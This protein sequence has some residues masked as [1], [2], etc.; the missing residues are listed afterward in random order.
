MR[1]FRV[2]SAFHQASRLHRLMEPSVLAE[3]VNRSS[4]G[5]SEL[6]SELERL[7]DQL[8]CLG[9]WRPLAA[10]P[11]VVDLVSLE[12]RFPNFSEVIRYVKGQLALAASTAAQIARISPILLLGPPGVGKS[13]FARAVAKEMAV[14]FFEIPV[15]TTTA[16]FALTGGDSSWSG[17][18]PGRIFE[19]LAFESVSNPLI[20]LD[21]VDKQGSDL[22]YDPLA[23]LLSV[24]EQG[25]AKAFRDEYAAIPVDASL[26]MWMATAN[27]TETMPEPLLS[28]FR[29]FDIPPPDRAQGEGICRSVYRNLREDHDWG[30]LFPVELRAEVIES[31]AVLSP[32]EMKKTLED[33]AGRAALAGRFVINREDLDVPVI[34]R[35]A[36]RIGF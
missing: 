32:R 24:L 10:I 1:P 19:I 3:L 18:K 27:S 36:S 6:R 34:H 25:N 8:R 5:S 2:V 16:S 33:A 31:L 21:E 28:R 12:E 23:A 26:I 35:P 30:V 7:A 14:S 13:A 17:A 29:V 20:L 11:K 4:T 15:N 22:R 9:P